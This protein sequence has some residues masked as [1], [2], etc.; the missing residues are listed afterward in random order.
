VRDTLAKTSGEGYALACEALGAADLRAEARKIKAPTLVMCGEND[1]PS[2]LESARWLAAN[3]AGA[4]LAWLPRA[5]H[6]SVIECPELAVSLL[7]E[8]L[9]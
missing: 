5:R 7:R 6:A 1:I 9:E 8:F 4:R 3:I 2:F